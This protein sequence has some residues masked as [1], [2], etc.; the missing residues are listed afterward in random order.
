MRD[1]RKLRLAY[2]VTHPIQYQ[3]PLLRLVAAQP[4]LD[5]TVFFGTDFSARAFTAG[6]FGREITWDVPLLDGYRHEVLPQLFTPPAGRQ[7]P[8]DFWRPLNYGLARRLAAGKFDALWVHGYAH[9]LHWWA[10][11]VAKRHGTK[12]LLRD[13]A[14][15]ISAERG[16]AKRAAKRAFFAGLNRMVDGFLTIGTLNR[17]YYAANGARADRLFD[18][19][20][21]VDNGHFSQGAAKAN[22][23][24]EPYRAA[25]GL[26]PGRPI[27][28]FAAKL[29]ERKRP[30]LLLEAFSRIHAD[31]A[32]RRPY[33]LFAGDGPLRPALEAQATAQAPGA[34]RFLGFQ[35]QSDLPR[36]YDL[37]DA[38]VLPSAQEAWGLVV[39][40]VMC[41]GRAVVASDRVGAA[42][43]LVR[44]GE[45]GAMFRTDD[46]DDLMRVLR[47]TLAD[48]ERLAAMGKR[49]REIIDRWSFAED[50]AGLRR[51][52]AAVCPAWSAPA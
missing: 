32:T 40:E 6:E 42:P 15:S 29:I 25:L 36:C 23:N 4:D 17:R 14:T 39:N 50:I 8:L 9:W 21:A 16:G 2:L 44:D 46:G 10:M 5:F 43:D 26:E 12:V 31:P 27:L 30:G 28:L 49:S 1:R 34:V 41:A 45:N 47:E 24:R 19:P 20:Y 33:L 37:C 51:A 52:L 11:A 48:P 35:K 18:M 3:A 13:E 22:L 38:F 7:P